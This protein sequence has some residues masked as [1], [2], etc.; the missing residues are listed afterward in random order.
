MKC[1][2]HLIS[3]IVNRRMII[4]NMPRTSLRFLST[5]SMRAC[6]CN[7]E[8]IHPIPSFLPYTFSTD[9]SER[10]ATLH[11]KVE[12]LVYIFN[13][14]DSHSGI[15]AVSTQLGAADDFLQPRRITNA[16]Y[17]DGRYQFRYPCSLHLQRLT[18][19]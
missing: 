13:A 17:G 7:H 8:L 1:M 9:V 6:V 4:H 14:L 12:S 16:E 18:S 3:A 11:N 10:H 19:N 15:H 2:T 5:M